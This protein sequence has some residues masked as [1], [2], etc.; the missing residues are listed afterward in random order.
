[1]FSQWLVIIALLVAVARGDPA[2]ARLYR[3]L[4]TNYS[5]LER[6][7][8]HFNETLIVTFGMALQQIVDV[9]STALVCS[10]RRSVICACSG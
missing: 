8:A 2:E 4:M 9:V 1:M 7:V 5:P 6:P 10:A 3:Q